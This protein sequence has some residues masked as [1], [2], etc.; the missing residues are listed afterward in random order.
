VYSGFKL[1]VVQFERPPFKRTSFFDKPDTFYDDERRVNSQDQTFYRQNSEISS[2]SVDEGVGYQT[3]R[4]PSHFLRR[5]L[6][7]MSLNSV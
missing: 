1:P 4:V 3:G 2:L 7:K 6:S 5:D